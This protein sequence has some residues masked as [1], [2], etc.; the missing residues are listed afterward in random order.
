MVRKQ[1]RLL[2]RRLTPREGPKRESYR[3]SR[4]T[5]GFSTPS[6]NEIIYNEK[7]PNNTGEQ[8]RQTGPVLIFLVSKK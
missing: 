1:R 2:R 5:R 8:Q 7:Q 4:E 6:K 3:E